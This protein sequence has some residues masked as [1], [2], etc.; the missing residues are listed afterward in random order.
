MKII[1]KKKR[2]KR[3][4]SKFAFGIVKERDIK[5]ILVN[6]NKGVIAEQFFIS[7]QIKLKALTE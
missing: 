6:I 5:Y 1:F 4:K 3:T 2:I 7:T